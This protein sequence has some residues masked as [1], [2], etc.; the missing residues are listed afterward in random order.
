ML[1][2]RRRT[3]RRTRTR[4]REERYEL[5]RPFGIYSLQ[6]CPSRLLQVRVH[7]REHLGGR[8]FAA[9]R[10]LALGLRHGIRVLLPGRHSC[11][12]WGGGEGR[13]GRGGGQCRMQPGAAAK[14]GQRGGRRAPMSLPA[15]LL[16]MP[17]STAPASSHSTQFAGVMP[18][19]GHSAIW[20]KLPM[21]RTA[22]SNAGLQSCAG[23]TLMAR[24]PWCSQRGR[25]WAAAAAAAA[26]TAATKHSS[27]RSS[28]NR[29]SQLSA[30]LRPRVVDLLRRERRRH[31]QHAPAVA[32]LDH[33]RRVD[34]R[35]REART[36]LGAQLN[37]RDVLH[38]PHADEAAVAHRGHQRRQDPLLLR[39]V[40][41][42]LDRLAAHRHQL[43]AALDRH[44]GVL[45]AQDRHHA[46]VTHLRFRPVELRLHRRGHDRVGPHLR[47][48][49]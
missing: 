43:D 23:K 32:R 2:H 19:D 39:R 3:S 5:E 34:R 4:E 45:R 49:S 36:E 38:R 10:P 31:R 8:R 46:R 33:A 42:H 17:T 21:P 44:I 9:L 26:A 1:R 29:S 12:R 37:L 18:P 13:E 30:H 41:R 40:P 28:S 27:N 20:P 16:P 6:L 48:R 14:A 47:H 22:L 7:V 35:E 25:Q 11:K 24:A 15:R